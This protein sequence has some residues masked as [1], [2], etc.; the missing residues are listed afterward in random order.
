MDE[1]IDESLEPYEMTLE[2]EIRADAAIAQ[3]ERDIEEMKAS[4]R[5]GFSEDAIPVEGPAADARV[6]D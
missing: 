4:G 3:A 5:W 1:R 2:E 6:P